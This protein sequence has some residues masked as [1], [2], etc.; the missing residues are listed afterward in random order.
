MT[1][2]RVVGMGV[3]MGASPL[4]MSTKEKVCVRLPSYKF[5][6]YNLWEGGFTGLESNHTNSI[7]AKNTHRPG[8]C[9]TAS[10]LF[11]L[12]KTGTWNDAVSNYPSNLS[13]AFLNSPGWDIRNPHAML[14]RA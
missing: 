3:G 9:P 1:W 11:S 2:F 10:F 6:L 12:N 7:G 8:I 4:Y 13:R 14:K 5:H